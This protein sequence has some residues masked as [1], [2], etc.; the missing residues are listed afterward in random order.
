MESRVNMCACV[1]TAGEVQTW[2]H[3]PLG[4]RS[5]NGLHSMAKAAQLLEQGSGHLFPGDD[6]WYDR[7]LWLW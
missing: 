5:D 4:R 3:R 2:Y 1:I 7:G 6:V